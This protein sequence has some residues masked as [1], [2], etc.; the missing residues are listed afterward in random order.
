[1]KSFGQYMNDSIGD[2]FPIRDQ[3]SPR[4]LWRIDALR[5]KGNVHVAANLEVAGAVVRTSSIP[6]GPAQPG[7]VCR[8][9][10]STPTRS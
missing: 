8:W 10:I 6:K 5:L 7:N 2:F 1:M 3:M 4:S 9:L